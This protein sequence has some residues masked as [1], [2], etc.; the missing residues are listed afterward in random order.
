MARHPGG[1]GSMGI[2][3]SMPSHRGGRKSMGKQTRGGN[4]AKAKVKSSA[5][6]SAK[7]AAMK[8]PY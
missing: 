7:G 2:H 8:S 6:F 1:S 5:R 3:G 4:L